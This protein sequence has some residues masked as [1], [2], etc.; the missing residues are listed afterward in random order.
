MNAINSRPQSL[1]I[2]FTSGA[3]AL[4]ALLSKAKLGKRKFARPA[5][6]NNGRNFLSG[7]IS[8][9]GLRRGITCAQFFMS[10]M[11]DL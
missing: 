6:E 1:S 3:W 9:H 4:E 11:F 7:I 10:V 5:G 8:S 2:L